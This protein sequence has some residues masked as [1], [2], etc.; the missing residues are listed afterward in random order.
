[1]PRDPKYCDH[2]WGDGPDEYS[3]MRTCAM[4]EDE[5]QTFQV[6]RCDVCKTFVIYVL[7]EPPT[8]V[9]TRKGPPGS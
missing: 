1:M 5:C 2:K 6:M 8:P 7:Q 4:F 3:K 9:E